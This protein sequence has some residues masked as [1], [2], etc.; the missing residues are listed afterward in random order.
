MIAGRARDLLEPEWYIRLCPQIK[1]HVGIDW[2]CVKALL[3][4]APPVAVSSH[5]SFINGKARL[6]TDG[7]WDCVQSPFHFLLREC[8][9]AESIAGEEKKSQLQVA[10]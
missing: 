5:G 1:L 7:A 6:L 3:A 9:H 4:D 8:D 2:K 10:E